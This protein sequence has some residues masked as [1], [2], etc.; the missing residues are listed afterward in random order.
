MNSIYTMDSSPGWDLTGDFLQDAQA[1]YPDYNGLHSSRHD[2][3]LAIL[4]RLLRNMAI[5]FGN[6]QLALQA[7]ILDHYRDVYL[8]GPQAANARSVLAYTL[9][10]WLPFVAFRPFVI[11]DDGID[12]PR[13]NAEVPE[14]PAPPQTIKPDP[15][16]EDDDVDDEVDATS[17]AMRQ[18]DR[19]EY[20]AERGLR[21]VPWR[22]VP[23]DAPRNHPLVLA[24]ASIGLAGSANDLR[25]YL[26]EI[27]PILLLVPSVASPPDVEAI[28]RSPAAERDQRLVE[29]I[30]KATDNLEQSH[31]AFRSELRGHDPDWG[32]LRPLLDSAAA[33]LRSEF[34]PSLGR[35]DRDIETLL[36]RIIDDLEPWTLRDTINTVALVATAAIVVA[37]M[38]AALPAAGAAVAGVAV[39][40]AALGLNVHLMRMENARRETL[41]AF[42]GIDVALTIAAP[43]LNVTREILMVAATYA[44]GPVVGGMLKLGRRVLI[45]RALT[46]SRLAVQSAKSAESAA[47]KAAVKVLDDAKQQSTSGVMGRAIDEAVETERTRATHMTARSTEPSQRWTGERTITDTTKAGDRRATSTT[48]RSEQAPHGGSGDRVAADADTPEWPPE[49]SEPVDESARA[50]S[51]AGH[52]AGQQPTRAGFLLDREQQDVVGA[53]LGRPLQDPPL[54]PSR[55]PGSRGAEITTAREIGEDLK[56]RIAAHWDAA[57]PED[58]N[59]VLEAADK[60]LT[61]VFTEQPANANKFVRQHLF[62]LWRKRAMTQIAKDRQLVHDLR[63]HAG[64]VLAKHPERQAKSLRLRGRDT[65]GERVHT[66]L[67]FDHAGIRHQ[68]AVD[69]ALQANDPNI[70]ARTVLSSELQ[71][72]TE[73]ENR[74]VLEALRKALRLLGVPI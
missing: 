72:V 52:T 17:E 35:F 11:I 19:E 65:A 32:T 63:E 12:A 30:K 41:N 27:D 59:S 39:D 54:K 56:K 15:R 6:E 22:A 34:A 62:D 66:W 5:D 8:T 31:R 58:C 50:R 2:R 51:V 61:K 14:G 57:L 55:L 68:D 48:P 3:D 60:T 7:A 1:I 4:K 42:S 26:Y 36:T 69:A 44:I 33:L 53:L 46:R 13:W 47:E 10:A 40:A 18:R 70:L 16:F 45:R 28:L 38:G 29:L 37:T 73:R 20:E 49:W 43:E 74:I 9:R 21:Y 23:A 24:Q 71:L 64:I 67:D 25:Q